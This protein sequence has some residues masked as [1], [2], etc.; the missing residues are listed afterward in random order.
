MISMRKEKVKCEF[1]GCRLGS[2]N[3]TV[4]TYKLLF[5]TGF[6][7]MRRSGAQNGSKR[8]TDENVGE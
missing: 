6:N 2:Q 4:N 5:K 7:W 8:E 3:F 1:K